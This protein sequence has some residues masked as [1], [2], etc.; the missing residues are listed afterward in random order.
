MGAVYLAMSGH[1]ELETLC[2]VKRLLPALLSQP[3]HVRN[4]RHEADLARQLVHSN[5]AH[6]HNIGEVGGEVF[7]VQEFVEGHDVSALLER[8]AAQGRVL[9]VPVAVYIVSEIAH[10]QIRR[11]AGLLGNETPGVTGLL[12]ER[13]E[14]GVDD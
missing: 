7:L 9:P 11:V 12:H 13:P 10:E 3:D 8:M 14:A 6:T 2:V 5:L 4:F 1:R